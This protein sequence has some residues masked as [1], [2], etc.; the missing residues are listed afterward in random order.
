MNIQS[1]IFILVI[2]LYGIYTMI[3]LIKCFKS[4]KMI[5]KAID[6]C[7]KAIKEKEVK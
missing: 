3:D 5:D 6:N 1:I 2:V 7:L 4:R